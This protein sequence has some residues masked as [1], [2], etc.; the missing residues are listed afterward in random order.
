MSYEGVA[1]LVHTDSDS[2]QNRTAQG[3]SWLPCRDAVLRIRFSRNRLARL[4]QQST[5]RVK[6]SF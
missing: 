2:I 6:D 4:C 5:D 3:E 1:L